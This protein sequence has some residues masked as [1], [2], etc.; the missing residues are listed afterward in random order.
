VAGIGLAVLAAFVTDWF[1]PTWS[2]MTFYL[3]LFAVLLVR[4]QGLF[5]KVATV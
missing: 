4:P 3:A 1:G 2:F 5:G